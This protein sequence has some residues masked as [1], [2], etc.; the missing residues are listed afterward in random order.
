MF[1]LVCSDNVSVNQEGMYRHRV[2]KALTVETVIRGIE[3]GDCTKETKEDEVN[4]F[5]HFSSG[6]S[7]PMLLPAG[8][9]CTLQPVSYGLS[10]LSDF[11]AKTIA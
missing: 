1:T 8:R 6:L 10:T 4:I 2:K 5:T 3:W 9:D 11:L 7:S